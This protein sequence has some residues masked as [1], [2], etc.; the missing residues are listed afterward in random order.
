MLMAEWPWLVYRRL[1]AHDGEI[2]IQGRARLIDFR[3]DR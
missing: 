3:L 2:T 1:A